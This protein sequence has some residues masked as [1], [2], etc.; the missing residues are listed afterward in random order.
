MFPKLAAWYLAQVVELVVDDDS[1]EPVLQEPQV[2]VDA[3]VLVEQ[4]DESLLDLQLE[5]FGFE[6]E[7]ALED[8]EASATQPTHTQSKKRKQQDSAG[9][10]PRRKHRKSKK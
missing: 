10:Q 1:G 3:D 6:I 2:A 8:A 5:L 9:K 7:V 4:L